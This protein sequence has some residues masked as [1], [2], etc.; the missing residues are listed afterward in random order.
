VILNFVLLFVSFWKYVQRLVSA[1][2]HVSV[3][4][5]LAATILPCLIVTVK[6]YIR[7]RYCG[8]QYHP[9]PPR[10]NID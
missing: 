1:I 2:N 9:A 3:G 10:C 8:V 6:R 7:S 4:L 5:A